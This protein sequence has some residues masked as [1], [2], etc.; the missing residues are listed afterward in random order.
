MAKTDLSCKF[1]FCPK[2]GVP[3]TNLF[4]KVCQ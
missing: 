2:L 4:D 1:D 3:E